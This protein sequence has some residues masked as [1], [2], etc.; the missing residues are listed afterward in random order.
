M[1]GSLVMT[2]QSSKKIPIFNAASG[3]VE[4][5]TLIVKTDEEWKALL[6]PQQFRV[7][8]KK[9]TE[10]AFTGEYHDFHGKGIYRCVCCGTDLF[11]SEFKFE[12][13]TGWP[14][15]TAPISPLNVRTEKDISYGMVR[16]EVLCS[17]CGAHLGH[18]FDDGPPP[19]ETRFCINSASLHFQEY[20]KKE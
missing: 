13:G 4:E 8:R 20:T 19:A 1:A 12:S 17:R 10:T 3:K 14:S 15:F 9:G 16:T 18:V 2:E 7:A 6:T 11:R 5:V